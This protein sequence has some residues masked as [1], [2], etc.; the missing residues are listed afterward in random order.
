MSL[1]VSNPIPSQIPF[2][3][4]CDLLSNRL[5]LRLVDVPLVA[6]MIELQKPKNFQDFVRNNNDFLLENPML[7]HFPIQSTKDALSGKVGVHNGFNI[8]NERGS[9]LF[10]LLTD[11]ACMLYTTEY[12]PDMIPLLSRE[13]GF[14]LFRRYEFAGTKALIDGLFQYNDATYELQ[15]HR[16]I[17]R[18]TAISAPAPASQGRPIVGDPHRLPEL[19][20]MSISFVKE[21]ETR[22][23]TSQTAAASLMK[24]IRESG[25]YCWEKERQICSVAEVLTNDYD[26]PVI[27]HFYTPANLRGKGYG[28][29]LIYEVTK[30]LLGAGNEFCMLSTNASNPASNKVF[31][32]VGY[33]PTGDYTLVYKTA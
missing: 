30:G 7:Y 19:I 17:Y 1:V 9:R 33:V 3:S 31:V 12:D 22:I 15:K 16:I 5:H 26:F 18:C 21:Y 20:P 23:I 29:S 28:T 4:K 10:A 2:K 24:S 32:K 14:E 25:L 11:V 8:F 6:I 13:I 27:G